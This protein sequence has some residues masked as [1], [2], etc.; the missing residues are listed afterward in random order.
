MWSSSQKFNESNFNLSI[1]ILHW[2]VELYQ[3]SLTDPIVIPTINVSLD[4]Q[5]ITPFETLS[6]FV[7]DDFNT[8]HVIHPPV[9]QTLIGLGGISIHNPNIAIIAFRGTMNTQEWVQDAKSL[10]LVSLTNIPDSFSYGGFEHMT[11]VKNVSDQV[12]VGD[13]FLNMYCTRIGIRNQKSGCVCS[14]DCSHGTCLYSAESNYSQFYKTCAKAG[15]LGVCHANQSSF[16][17]LN[18]QVFDFVTRHN[19]TKIIVIGHS[20]GAA[21]ANLCSFHLIHAFHPSIIHSVY[22]FASPRTGN[23]DFALSLFPIYNIYYTMINSN[24]IVPSLPPPWPICFCHVGMI[25]T[26]TYLKSDWACDFH[27][28]TLMHDLETYRANYNYMS[29]NK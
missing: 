17:S 26:F 21:L 6:T 22:S 20:L 29:I 23:A 7:D 15:S 5:A 24:D 13:G 19:V 2:I 14:S 1:N 16:S 11:G 10:K 12:K 4:L 8:H 9:R 18:K 27:Y 25:K 3:K 28:V